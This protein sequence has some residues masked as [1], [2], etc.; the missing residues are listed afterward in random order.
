MQADFFLIMRTEGSLGVILFEIT[1]GK[2]PFEE[3]NAYD[4]YRQ[5]KEGSYKMPKFLSPPLKKMLGGILVVDPKKRLSM[6]KIYEEPWMQS[7]K[8]RNKTSKKKKGKKK[9]AIAKSLSCPALKTMLKKDAPE[10]S[11]LA[12]KSRSLA[13]GLH[14][15]NSLEAFSRMLN[16]KPSTHKDSPMPP[17]GP[18]QRRPSMPRDKPYDRYA[19]I[20]K[21]NIIF[22]A[23]KK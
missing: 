14:A 4:T 20:S 1:S 22:F 15:F 8:Y 19:L 2:R 6:E 16:R 7:C 5:I 12:K 9:K 11:K 3:E 21:A 23:Y 17:M 18:T 10:D 13:P